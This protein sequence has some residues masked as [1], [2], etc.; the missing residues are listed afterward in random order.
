MYY[1]PLT[2]VSC[3]IIDKSSFHIHVT[4][5]IGASDN[6]VTTAL[7]MG[8]EKW[9]RIKISFTPS[10]RKVITNYRQQ[11]WLIHLMFCQLKKRENKA[12]LPLHPS[13]NVVPLF[14]LHVSVQNNKHPNF[15]RWG[16]GVVLSPQ[17]LHLRTILLP[18]VKN[19]WRG[20]WQAKCYQSKHEAIKMGIH[21]EWAGN[22]WICY[23]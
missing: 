7:Q 8:L 4:F 12:F 6:L 22:I 14:K 11:N 17:L 15:R 2:Q 3:V 10:L 1:S 13:R 21:F 20:T 5:R 19:S 18:V 16:R 23:C 9:K